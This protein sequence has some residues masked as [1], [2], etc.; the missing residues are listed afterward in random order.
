MAIYGEDSDEEP[1]A[2]HRMQVKASVAK[3]RP[4][5]TTVLATAR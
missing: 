3:A 1:E 2:I 4:S 5:A